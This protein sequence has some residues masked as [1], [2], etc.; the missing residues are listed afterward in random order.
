MPML[1]A[2]TLAALTMIRSTVKKID[3]QRRLMARLHWSVLDEVVDKSVMVS[4]EIAFYDSA[5]IGMLDWKPSLRQ[6][7]LDRDTAWRLRR[8]KLATMKLESA[9]RLYGF[10]AGSADVWVVE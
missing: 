10:L 7:G 6:H 2:K 3:E 9:I 5:S 8:D 1:N 4:V